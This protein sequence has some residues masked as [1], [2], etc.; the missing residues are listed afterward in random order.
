M[1]FAGAF[2][3]AKSLLT[4]TIIKCA[5]DYNAQLGCEMLLPTS[6]E[7][8]LQLETRLTRGEPRCIL[9]GEISDDFGRGE[10]VFSRQHQTGFCEAVDYETQG[11]GIAA[12]NT[13]ADTKNL[14]D[15][16][17]D[18]GTTGRSLECRYSVIAET[19][20]DVDHLKLFISLVDTNSPFG[21]RIRL[22][23][24]GDNL[25]KLVDPDNQI[26]GRDDGSFIRED[27]AVSFECGSAQSSTWHIEVPSHSVSLAVHFDDGSAPDVGGNLTIIADTVFLDKGRQLETPSGGKPQ[28]GTGRIQP[29]KV[30]EI[31]DQVENTA[32]HLLADEL[33]N[34]FVSGENKLIYSSS[35]T[36]DDSNTEYP[37]I[38]P[39][40][41]DVVVS[42]K[43]LVFH[44]EDIILGTEGMFINR[45]AGDVSYISANLPDWLF[46]DQINGDLMGTVPVHGDDEEEDLEFSIYAVDGAGHSAKAV[47]LVNCLIPKTRAGENLKDYEFCEGG[48]VSIA[49]KTMFIEFG[50]DVES[51]QFTAAGLP[52]GLSI[53]QDDGLISGKIIFGTATDA[54]YEI[55]V[56]AHD[57]T[58]AGSETS[59]RFLINVVADKV[60]ANGMGLSY[61]PIAMNDLYRMNKDCER[62]LVANM[63]AN[64]T[65]IAQGYSEQEL[66]LP[67]AND[68]VDT[69]HMIAP[70]VHAFT[71]ERQI[72]LQVHNGEETEAG[73]C[74]FRY[75]I[76]LPGENELPDWIEFTPNGLIQIGC[77]PKRRFIDLELTQSGD[78]GFLA[79]YD[80]CVDTFEGSLLPALHQSDSFLDKQLREVSAA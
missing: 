74:N 54:P 36:S 68:F 4:I 60:A 49:T 17:D 52:E 14:D 27:E 64:L 48:H 16:T 53:G 6:N 38:S 35:E 50:L 56:T 21:M 77:D 18:Q 22:T 33:E 39:S 79:R 45:V 19:G 32:E 41:I 76:Q 5:M 55:V 65:G 61:S 67:A 66:Q 37:D 12:I 9:R 34:G 75:E 31:I 13:V 3:I 59:M 70:I 2:K 73:E 20:C 24:R 62:I 30:L 71:P 28:S 40:K 80:I 26:I 69:D 72:F 43:I 29:E 78:D 15:K 58:T 47:I 10:F 7:P 44:G 46:L 23:W 25:A 42:Q 1:K 57:K 11:K 63:A 8:S 51:L